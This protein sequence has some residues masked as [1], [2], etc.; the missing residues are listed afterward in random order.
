MK[1]LV[2]M[3]LAF[4]VFCAGCS[5]DSKPVKVTWGYVELTKTDNGEAREAG[6]K[7]T[8]R[9]GGD[10]MVEIQGKRLEV[11]AV[12][13]AK[14]K[15]RFSGDDPGDKQEAELQPGKSTDLWKVHLAFG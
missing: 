10:E 3:L 6:G 5:H 4:L 2:L 7:H 12:T 15:F 8:L 14:A 9:S 13:P 1:S 11:V